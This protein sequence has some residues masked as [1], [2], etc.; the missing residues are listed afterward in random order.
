MVR[1]WE[2][3]H[4]TLLAAARFVGGFNERKRRGAIAKRPGCHLEHRVSKSPERHYERHVEGS[5]LRPRSTLRME[6]ISC[7]NQW[8]SSRIHRRSTDLRISAESWLTGL[9]VAR[10]LDNSG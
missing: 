7:D 4:D 3:R 1:E 2:S 5:A 10:D 8:L 9:H 6:R